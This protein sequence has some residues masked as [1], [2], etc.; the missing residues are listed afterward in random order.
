[1]SNEF[2][3]VKAITTLAVTGVTTAGGSLSL[4]QQLTVLYPFLY[5]QLPLYIFFI[6]IALMCLTGSILALLTDVM[7]SEPSTFKKVSLAFIVGLVSAFIVLPSL[8]AVPSMGTLLLTA[9]GSSFS[10]TVLVFI[11]AQVIKDN[12]LQNTIKNSISKSIIYG[13]SKLDKF[14]DFLSGNKK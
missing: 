2:I 3:A 5:L 11:F 6:L 9:L 12:T 8:V 7:D 1:M 4:I 10:G 13:F 14:I